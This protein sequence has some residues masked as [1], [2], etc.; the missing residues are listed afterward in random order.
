MA[1]QTF[2]QAQTTDMSAISIAPDPLF[3][4][5]PYLYMQFHG[6]ARN[7]GRLREASWDHMQHKWRPDLIAATKGISAADDAVGRAF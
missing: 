7:D 6:A 1:A 5:S 4:L 3:E 2:A